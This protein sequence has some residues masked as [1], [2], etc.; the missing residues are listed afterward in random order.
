MQKS[1]A[2]NRFV[3]IVER[4]EVVD[5]LYGITKEEREVLDVIHGVKD[6]AFEDSDDFD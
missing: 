1:G 2:S 5:A 3:G 6:L 4:L